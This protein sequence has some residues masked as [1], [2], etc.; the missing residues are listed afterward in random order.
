M[1]VFRENHVFFHK[2]TDFSVNSALFARFQ[3]TVEFTRFNELFQRIESTL[4][5]EP[6]KNV[7]E[8]DAVHDRVTAFEP[9]NPGQLLDR[10]EL[11]RRILFW[12]TSVYPS[13]NLQ[14][15]ILKAPIVIHKPF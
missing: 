14:F 2:N 11:E 15:R 13:F 3:E 8:F 1:L 5:A 9:G 7:F 6:R 4:T 12:L 10:A